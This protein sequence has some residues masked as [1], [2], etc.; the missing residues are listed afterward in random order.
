M[1]AVL[2]A[3]AFLLFLLAIPH[4]SFCEPPPNDDLGVMLTYRGLFRL[5]FHKDA[6][7]DDVH[8]EHDGNNGLYIGGREDYLAKIGIVSPIVKNIS[9]YMLNPCSRITGSTSQGNTVYIAE[10][11]VDNTRS[12]Y[13]SLPLIHVFTV[14]S[15]PPTPPGALKIERLSN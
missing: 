13:T 3:F 11:G 4:T 15:A 2:R 12:Y 9:Q 1:V 10:R 6:F 7:R 8:I 5:P 14:S